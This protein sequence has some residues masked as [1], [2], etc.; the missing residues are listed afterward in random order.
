MRKELPYSSKLSHPPKLGVGNCGGNASSLSSPRA[1]L[2]HVS[3]LAENPRQVVVFR[4]AERILLCGFRVF[5][6]T[7]T[8]IHCL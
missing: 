7:N 6:P 8:T 1:L 5:R 2:L 4:E 3:P